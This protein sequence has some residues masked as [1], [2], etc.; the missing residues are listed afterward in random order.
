MESEGTT[1]NDSALNDQD[2]AIGIVLLY[3]SWWTT[4][5]EQDL[6]LELIR[7]TRTRYRC[8]R[9]CATKNTTLEQKQEHPGFQR[10]PPP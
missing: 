7:R 8:D 2:T 10:G 4:N 3:A 1:D 6:L 9:D 5:N